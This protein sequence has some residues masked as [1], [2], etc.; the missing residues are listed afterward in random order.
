MQNIEKST[1]MFS[2]SI[3]LYVSKVQVRQIETQ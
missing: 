1:I 2:I 3:I